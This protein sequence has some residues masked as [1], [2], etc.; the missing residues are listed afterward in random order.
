FSMPIKMK[1]IASTMTKETRKMPGNTMAAPETIIARIPKP[2]CAA[3]IQPGDLSE[4]MLL[5]YDFYAIVFYLS[6]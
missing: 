4:I 5:S 6:K 2:I 3:L 1:T